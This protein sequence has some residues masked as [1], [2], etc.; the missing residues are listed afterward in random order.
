VSKIQFIPSRYRGVYDGNTLYRLFDEVLDVAGGSRFVLIAPEARGQHVGDRN[1]WMP[2]VDFVEP[3]DASD[4][5]ALSIRERIG[6][7]V[8]SGLEV[9]AQAVPDLTVA[10]SEGVCY[11]P[12]GLRFAPA[13]VEALVVAT[14][15]ALKNRKA[16]VYVSAAGVVT[17]L[18]AFGTTAVAGAK[19]FTI[20]TNAVATDKIT[21]GGVEFTAVASGAAGAQFN[22]GADAAETAANLAAVLDANATVGAKHD[23]AAD[24]AA[25]TLTEKVP[26][27]GDTPADATFTGTVVVTNG[28][29]TASAAAGAASATALPAG[30]VLLAEIEVAAGATT[31]QTANITKKR[32]M[33]VTDA[34]FKTE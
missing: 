22:V 6:N 3:L 31:I 9:T 4:G 25:I 11:T 27:G 16:I 20:A 21:I 28:A 13:A 24:G 1:L 18:S 15:E 17:A 12:G 10:V 29:A 8:I 7:G 5:L 14:V 33:L 19:T 30:G 26:G 32:K 23:A 34:V 2:V